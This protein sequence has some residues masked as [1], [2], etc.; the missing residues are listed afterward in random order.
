M[1]SLELTQA[2]AAGTW[3]QKAL[4]AMSETKRALSRSDAGK[5][6]LHANR[7][8]VMRLALTLHGLDNGGGKRVKLVIDLIMAC[9]F[10]LFSLC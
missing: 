8:M 6:W 4:A 5:K 10:S 7:C 2:G 3:R 9:V 1:L